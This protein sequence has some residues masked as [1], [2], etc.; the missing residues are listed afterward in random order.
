MSNSI[1]SQSNLS[2]L[3]E[4]ISDVFFRYIIYPEY[5]LDYI[6]PSVFELTGYTQEEFYANPFLAYN[7]LHSEDSEIKKKSEEAIKNNKVQEKGVVV[8]NIELRTIK[9]DGTVIWTETIS[10]VVKN[11]GGIIT[12][13]EVVTRDITARKKLE[14]E[15]K[16]VAENYRLLLENMPCAVIIFNKE[17]LFF[18]NQ[19]AL[20][21]VGLDSNYIF[22]NTQMSILNFIDDDYHN[23]LELRIKKLFEG[24]TTTPIEIK[25]KQKDGTTLFVESQSTLVDYYGKKAI[26]TILTDISK[27]KI[28]ELSWVESE[29]KFA[30]LSKFSPVGVFITNKLGIPVFINKKCCEI[31]GLSEKEIL[32]NEWYKIILEEYRSVVMEMVFV[33]VMNQKDLETKFKILNPVSNEICWIEIKSAIIKGEEESVSGWIGTVEDITVKK[34]AEEKKNLHF[35]QTPLGI[36]EWDRDFKVIRWN[37]AA[38]RIFGYSKEEALV[39]NGR[40]IIFEKDVN[41]VD[42]EWVKLIN[43][44]E[45]IKV[46]NKNITKDKRIILCEWNNTPLV[47]EHGKVVGVASL[48]QDVTEQ[49]RIQKALKDSERSLS[50]LMNNLPGMAYRCKND[51][52]WTME[53]VSKGC[54]ELTGYDSTEFINNNKLSYS[55]TTSQEEKEADWKTIQSAL[56][57]KTPFTVNY[58]LITKQGEVKWVWEQGEGIYNENGEAEAI[59][60]FIMDVTQ[61]KTAEE[62]FRSLVDFSP[63]GIFIH[64]EGKIVFINKSGMNILGTQNVEEAYKENIF[65]Y[66]LPEY[67]EDSLERVSRVVQ[68]EHVP[69]VG[70][71]VKIAS[72]EI[73]DVE[74]KSLLI[75]YEGKPAIQTVVHD[76]S[77]QKKLEKEVMRAEFAEETNALLEQEIT[78]RK[79]AQLRQKEV[80]QQIIAQAAKTQAIFDSSSHH[81]WTINKDLTITSFNKNYAA[82]LQEN[83]GLFPIENKTNL[84]EL[85]QSKE[86]R[87]VFKENY[88]KAFIGIPQQFE[89][90]GTSVHGKEFATEVNLQ[91]IFSAGGEIKEVSGIGHNITERRKIQEQVSVQAA[92][93]KAI[94]EASTHLVWTINRDFELTSF[95]YQFECFIKAV[96]GTK[97]KIGIAVNKGKMIS[98][99]EVNSAWTQ[100]MKN[101]F[102]GS[103]QQFETSFQTKKGVTFWTEVFVNP[104]YGNSGKVIEVSGIAHN[105]TEKKQAE[106]EIKQ[107]LKEKEI[108]VKEVHHRVK[109]NLQVISSILSLQ[110]SYTKNKQTIELLKEIQNRVKSMAFI[111]ESLYQSKDLTQINF[112][113]Y[114]S[115]LSTNLLHSYI[116]KEKEIDLKIDAPRLY[117][118]LDQ[119]IPCGLIVNELVSNSFKYAFEKRK[120]GLVKIVVKEV[121]NEI[122]IVISDDGIGLPKSIDYKNTESLGLQLV[123]ALA[124]Q[125][126]GKIK[127]SRTGGTKYTLTFLKNTK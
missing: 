31:A 115:T 56:K 69:F 107:S 78:K 110:S 60:G 19:Q 86:E 34:N 125:L 24:E 127:L 21:M 82:S 1:K 16:S 112:S 95:N 39:L 11:D 66:L 77:Q 47:N 92:K 14:L 81:I 84:E 7:T 73:K 74:V 72:G 118:S 43:N 51:R 53:F 64:Q 44:I 33:S 98:T 103:V 120:K 3:L 99:A 101:A 5:K 91:P 124:E 52:M 89:F 10:K 42:Q 9:K 67:K 93:L 35:E 106:I 15:A 68:G 59:E 116:T 48:V 13:V 26:Q 90:I 114:I 119:S 121:K 111:H 38:E 37:P 113:E 88:S 45:V 17:E 27:R 117:L 20:N 104:I 40:D 122:R 85:K 58:R 97:P 28:A 83:Y 12:S 29:K 25:I 36:I 105:I 4:N 63:D 70:V 96:Y 54:K 123:T 80:E 109:N 23:I 94:F 50:T 22:P 76:A 100:T 2:G 55:D 126:S 18:A 57:N 79:V 87:E 8:G 61:I 65:D 71:R 62:K 32:N 75:N 6:S 41:K 46:T 49:Y 102:G 30:T 108:L